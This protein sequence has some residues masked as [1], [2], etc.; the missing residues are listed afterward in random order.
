MTTSVTKKAKAYKHQVKRSPFCRKA[1]VEDRMMRRA[2]ACSSAVTVALRRAPVRGNQLVS[3]QRVM[4][5]HSRVLKPIQRVPSNALHRTA[6]GETLAHRETP[7]FAGVTSPPPSLRQRYTPAFRG[8]AGLCV[9]HGALRQHAH[10]V[11]PMAMVGS[12][13]IQRFH[14]K[15]A[16][17]DVAPFRLDKRYATYTMRM[18]LFTIA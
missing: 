5:V 14:S 18:L 11:D 2:L 17:D 6:K 8:A 4:L 13:R 3:M 7:L 12:S 16:D 10:S 9:Q 1:S 15:S